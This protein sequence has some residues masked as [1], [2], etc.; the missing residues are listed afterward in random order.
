MRLLATTLIIF[1]TI[2][3]FANAQSAWEGLYAGGSF[4]VFRGENTYANSD[5]DLGFNLEGDMFGAFAGYNTLFNGLVVG[6]ELALMAGAANEEGFAGQYEY[7][8]FVDI[9]GKV[10]LIAG[11]FM[12]YLMLGASIGTLEVDEEGRP[13]RNFDQTETGMLIGA[14]ADF[15]VNGQFAVGAE[16][17]SRRFDFDFGDVPLVD[18]E[19]NV[20]S[21]A[22]RGLYRF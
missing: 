2:S 15:A 22:L 13:D 8:S 6:G 12:P 20:N 4:A 9:K 19:A 16:V 11:E 14:G 5:G 3:S 1:T 18:M 10:G 17:M 21:F 7:S